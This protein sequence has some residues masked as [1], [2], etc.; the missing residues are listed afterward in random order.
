MA[1]NPGRRA[2][3][4]PGGG[5]TLGMT[6]DEFDYLRERSPEQ[7]EAADDVE[8]NPAAGVPGRDPAP[9]NAQ[10]GDV[11]GERARTPQ[12]GL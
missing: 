4:P 5:Y 2:R 10:G 8:E 11:D 3:S 12:S 1:H 7:D 9:G 6:D